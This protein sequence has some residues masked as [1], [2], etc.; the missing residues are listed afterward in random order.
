MS[1]KIKQLQILREDTELV[2]EIIKHKIIAD[3]FPIKNPEIDINKFQF[4][5]MYIWSKVSNII[6]STINIYLPPTIV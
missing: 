6:C 1:N 4:I 3:K 5:S 2:K